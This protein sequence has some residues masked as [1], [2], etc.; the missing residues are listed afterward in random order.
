MKAKKIVLLVTYVL[1]II[2]SLIYFLTNTSNTLVSACN[3]LTCLS[4][5]VTLAPGEQQTV[6]ANFSLHQ[7]SNQGLVVNKYQAGAVQLVQES[8]QNV[9]LVPFRGSSTHFMGI[10]LPKKLPKEPK[11]EIRISNSR[12]LVVFLNGSVLY[13]HRYQSPVFY[14]TSVSEVGNYTTSNLVVISK[15]YKDNRIKDDLKLLFTA[16]ILVGPAFLFYAYL[17]KKRTRKPGPSQYKRWYFRLCL[18]LSLIWLTRL[19]VWFLQANND[20]EHTVPTPFGPSPPFFSDVFQVFQASRYPKPYNFLASSYPPLASAFSHSFNFLTDGLKVMMIAE[21]SLMLWIWIFKKTTDLL[22]DGESKYV[23]YLVFFSLPF[24]FSIFRGNLDLL[25]TG[26]LGWGLI[27]ISNGQKRITCI[28]FSFAIA[29]KYWPILIVIFLWKKIG[30]K[31]I[32]ASVFG[33]FLISVLSA[34]VCGYHDFHSITHVLLLPIGEYA[35]SGGTNQ[36][37]YSYSL[38][39]IFFFIAIFAKST[40]PFHPNGLDISEA[41]NILTSNFFLMFKITFL[42]IAFSISK[43]SQ[44]ISSLVLY[45]TSAALLLTNTSFTYRGTVLIMLLLLRFE[46]EHKWTRFIGAKKWVDSGLQTKFCICLEGLAWIFIFA[47]LD[48]FYVSGSSISAESVLQP[49][50]VLALMFIEYRSHSANQM[51]NV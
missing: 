2:I 20:P 1:A 25:A 10:L 26:F 13:T 38:S 50:S 18:T 32:I 33:A 41:Q 6:T 48:F 4:K 31:V 8:G 12:I 7:I 30:I 29:L 45:G 37:A 21:I 19:L 3:S 5:T 44:K 16:T 35:L 27:K 40:H 39:S 22:H 42:L 24:L 47:P 9:L 34:W 51:G 17:G 23:L 14:I 49:L 36:I 11:F 46:T 43:T 15:I 28:A